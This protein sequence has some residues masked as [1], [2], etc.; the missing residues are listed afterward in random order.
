MTATLAAALAV[1]LVALAGSLA[2]VRRLR[3]LLRHERQTNDWREAVL[4][5]RT[6]KDAAHE[7]PRPKGLRRKEPPR[8]G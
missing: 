7:P 3:K 5:H 2:E 8:H 1:A 4:N 6:R